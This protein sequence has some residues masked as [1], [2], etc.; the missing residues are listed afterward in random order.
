MEVLEVGPGEILFHEG[1]ESDHAY[2][3]LDGEIEIYRPQSQGNVMLASFG[4]G[5]LFGEMGIID[6]QPRSATAKAK[7]HC[8]LKM[9]TREMI[10]HAIRTQ[11]SEFVLLIKA[12]MERLRE[13]NQTLMNALTY[14]EQMQVEQPA[15][16]DAPTSPPINRLTLK[17]LT[18]AAS[19]GFSSQGMELSSLPF[20][21]GG[22]PPGKESNP[23][24]YNNLYIENA[25]PQ[26]LSRNHF[27]IQKTSDGLYVSDRGSAQGTTVNGTP[28]G[29]HGTGYKAPLKP[30]KNVIIAGPPQ[31]LY[32]FELIWE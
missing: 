5:Q 18:E 20:R 25:D 12:L 27:S 31:S 3:I 9:V 10:V 1:D 32:Q 28:I 6:D 16:P 4:R 23:L 11:P 26:I 13:T 8:R 19:Q 14:Q 15:S 21:I 22:T 24:D 29:K 7:T 2:I 30:G 17:P